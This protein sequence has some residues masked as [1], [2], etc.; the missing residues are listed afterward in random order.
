MVKA[1]RLSILAAFASCVMLLGGCEM[2]NQEQWVPQEPNA[3]S[4]SEDGVITEIVQ[5]SLD[6]AYY[7]VAELQNMINA[8]VADYNKKNGE[9]CVTV[10][11]FENE[12]RSVK[13]EM[14]YA[15][16]KDYA[17]FNNIEFYYGS[18]INAQLEGYLFDVTYKKVHDGVVTGNSV[19]GS[20]VIKEMD[21][22]VMI[23]RAPLEINVPGS[24]LYTSSNA[25]VLTDNVVHA[26]GEQNE[27]KKEEGL[28]LPSN[29]VYVS[30]SDASFDEV[31][32]ANRV[33]IIFEMNY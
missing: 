15:S 13:L 27:V 2:L 32:A 31:E 10:K 21:K 22:E 19:S 5:E 33:Y 24:V 7:N 28:V 29:T 9:N 20:E 1:K 3:I 6:A 26:T 14:V 8:E 25:E 4:I 18:L 30:E 11:T 12:G 16:A 23:V 17:S